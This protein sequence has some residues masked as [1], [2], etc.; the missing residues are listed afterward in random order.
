MRKT[1]FLTATI[2]VFIAAN[3]VTADTR[4]VDP[5]TPLD[6]YISFG[7]FETPGDLD[8]FTQQGGIG[9]LTVAGGTLSGTI[10][11][12]DPWIRKDYGVNAGRF[13]LPAG[14]VLE[15]R[16]KFDANEALTNQ[17][18]YYYL[19]DGAWHPVAFAASSQ[20]QTN[21]EFHVYRITTSANN[22]FSWIMRVDMLA[23]ADM[24]GQNFEIDYI[25][26]SLPV[27]IDPVNPAGKYFAS[28]A[29]LADWNTPGD[30]ENWSLNG[31]D[32][33]AAGGYL[34]VTNMVGDC[35]VTKNNAAG[36]PQVDLD[37]ASGKIV[38]V[39]MRNAGT[40]AGKQF[41]YGT[42][43]TQGISGARVLQFLGG[44]LNTDGD[45]HIYQ[46]DMRN[47]SAWTGT[48]ETLRLDPSSTAGLIL[49]IDYIR[50]G[51]VIP[52]PATLGLLCLLGLAFLRRK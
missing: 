51:K 13:N 46:F 8:G 11:G 39:R 32:G 34:V 47:Q 31:L 40:D 16:I 41:Y 14:S 43:V 50:V 9:T 21:G 44:T 3:F 7:E 42:S 28:T 2:I 19:H 25:R 27:S 18:G 30:L 36:L 24:V 1:L 48:L 26:A 12:A 49:D 52:E 35:N 37:A 23:G 45:F 4:E 29:S 15:I 5:A 17:A 38:Q 22:N 33:E 10:T 20:I 6:T